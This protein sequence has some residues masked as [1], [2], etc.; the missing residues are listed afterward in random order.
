MVEEYFDIVDKENWPTGKVKLRS[1]VHRD[2]DWHQV[3]HIY[4]V[5]GKGNYLVHL[6]SVKKDLSPHKWDTRFGGHVK[7]GEEIL[8]TA[9][10][11]LGEEIGISPE[12]EFSRR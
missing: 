11:E 5:D 3:V 6:R 1:E 9:L 4:I 12:R 2:G 8:E 10:A 7:A